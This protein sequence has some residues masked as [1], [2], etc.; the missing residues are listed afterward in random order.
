MS[1]QT[2]SLPAARA[3]REREPPISRLVKKGMPLT[4]FSSGDLWRDAHASSKAS[5]NPIRVAR[6]LKENDSGDSLRDTSRQQLS[7]NRRGPA[8]P[9]SE[10]ALEIALT[11][12]RHAADEAWRLLQEAMIE[13]RASKIQVLLSIHN[14]AV[15]A[16]FRAESAHREELERQRILI[17]LTEAMAE[18]R[19][20]YE[21]ILQRLKGPPGPSHSRPR[22]RP[23]QYGAG[24]VPY[25]AGRRTVPV[26]LGQSC[27]S[28]CS[29]TV[30]YEA[31]AT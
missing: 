14:K 17:P 11:N 30:V 8:E 13:G 18:A 7:E 15:D 6:M 5:T 3:K 31:R 1:L 27:N 26:E 21:I 22:A 4:S 29:L 2:P 23:G 28:S 19:R 24:P 16:L 9:W 12:T 20:G 10:N 25:G